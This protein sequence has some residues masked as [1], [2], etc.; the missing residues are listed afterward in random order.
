MELLLYFAA[1]VAAEGPATYRVLSYLLLREAGKYAFP[2][3]SSTLSTCATQCNDALGAIRLQEAQLSQVRADLLALA[4]TQVGLRDIIVAGHDSGLAELHAIRDAVEQKCGKEE[5]CERL[6]DRLAELQASLDEQTTLI[7]SQ[8]V[9]DVAHDAIANALRELNH[10]I[11]GLGLEGYGALDRKLEE[12]KELFRAQATTPQDL[13]HRL[14]E[15]RHA[16]QALN[17][18]LVKELRELREPPESPGDPAA[19][20]RR[21]RPKP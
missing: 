17:Q 11:S 1:A 9:G 7:R 6:C 4:Q 13:L 5:L 21:K 16:V 2:S 8:M 12:L 19:K 20:V 15:L 3:G 14:D 18:E 10:L